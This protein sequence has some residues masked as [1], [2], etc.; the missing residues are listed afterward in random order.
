MNRIK[1]TKILCQSSLEDV[2]TLVSSIESSTEIKMIESANQGL[3][4]IKMRDSAQLEQFFLGEVLV[5]ECKVMIDSVIG[6]GI[7]EGA[8][9]ERARAMAIVDAMYNGNSKMKESVTDKLEALEE[10][11]EKIKRD[12]C[13]MLL[14]TKVDFETLYE[15]VKS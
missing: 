7:V 15:E 4:M 12:E 11:F 8:Q 9:E 6:I 14:N 3:V 1:R 10:K 13:K 2:M 5:T